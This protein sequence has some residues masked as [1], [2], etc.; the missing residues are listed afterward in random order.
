MTRLA[1][2]VVLTLWTVACA[3]GLT[4]GDRFYL[5]GDLVQAEEAYRSYLT[6]GRAE[7]NAEAR[8]RYRLGLIYALPKSDLHDI[9]KAERALHTLM[10][11]EPES[12][13][14]RQ[15]AL[16][17]DL[18]SERQ[19]LSDELDKQKKR[20][21]FLVGEIARAQEVATRAGDEVEDRDASVERLT[22]EI[23]GLRQS[24]SQLQEQVDE[25]ERELEQIK[26]VDLQP[27]P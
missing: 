6:A 25:R 23:G 15:A 24:I 3:T 11:R 19:R 18:W 21:D 20:A 13:W 9:E 16:L 2:L 14:A 7:G 10:E 17:L 12:A 27:P 8:A 26:R 1:A 5:A 22:R 4:E